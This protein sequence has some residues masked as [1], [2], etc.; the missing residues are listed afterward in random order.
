LIVIIVII[1]FIIVFI[2][3]II[4]VIF[5]FF[6]T[7][8]R[9]INGGNLIITFALFIDSISARFINNFKGAAPVISFTNGRVANI[10]IYNSSATCIS[11]FSVMR[12]SFNIIVR[13]VSDFIASVSYVCYYCFYCFYCCYC[14]CIFIN[15]KKPWKYIWVNVRIKFL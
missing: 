4:I 1:L 2:I 7:R 3:V 14:N 5:V 10:N 8:V 6:F 9:F 15:I 13:S 11:G 12:R